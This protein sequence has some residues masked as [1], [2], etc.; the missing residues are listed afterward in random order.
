MTIIKGKLDPFFETGTEGIIWSVYEDGK[1]GYDGL[2][3]LK[4]GDFLRI[5]D[6]DNP[7]KVI[8]EGIID[9]EWE[10]NYRNYPRNPEYG[11]Q[12]IGGF[13]VRGIQSTVTPEQWAQWFFKEYPAEMIP[14]A[15]L[16][17][18]DPDWTAEEEE[19][20][21]LLTKKADNESF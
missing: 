6:I 11:Q 20:F 5:F 18:L 21:N 4:D 14:A 10:R 15:D 7:S 17:K 16:P 19:E 12:E 9:L 3:C 13:W 8:W 1:T 2:N